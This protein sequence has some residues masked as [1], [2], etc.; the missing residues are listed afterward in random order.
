MALSQIWHNFG[1]F[2]IALSLSSKIFI[3]QFDMLA[4]SISFHSHVLIQKFNIRGATYEHFDLLMRSC[5]R[6][7]QLCH[8]WSIFFIALPLSFPFLIFK[9]HMLA[10]SLRFDLRVWTHKSNLTRATYEHF[11][12]LMRFCVCFPQLWHNCGIFF[13]ALPLSF[14]ILF[15]QFN[16]RAF[17]PSFN[18]HFSTQKSNFTWPSYK[19]FY[20]LMRSCVCLPQLWHNFGIF[21]IS[22]PLSFKILIYQIHMITCSP[23]LISHVWTQK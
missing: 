7:P 1:I 16:I 19:H 11:D 20:L 9:F 18:S 8:N 5:V 14:Q 4:S 17:S 13:K 10:C 23:S 3:F 2:F 15:F 22:L 21:F 12:L 6:L